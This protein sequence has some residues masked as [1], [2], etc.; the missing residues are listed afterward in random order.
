MDYH[1]AKASDKLN[2]ADRIDNLLAYKGDFNDLSVKAAYRFADR[3]ESYDSIDDNDAD[4]F[5]LSGIYTVADT[6]LAI[7]L[8]YAD[9][10]DKANQ[11]ML[12][13][14]Y[15]WNDLYVSALYSAA[16]LDNTD[17]DYDGFELAA[18]YK[19]EK[20]VFM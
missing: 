1:G 9:E 18:S 16:D 8:G 19:M 6:G 5:S 15:T 2:S 12:T 3:D 13:A 7:G 11:W 4:A 17:N 20:T 14:S 10:D